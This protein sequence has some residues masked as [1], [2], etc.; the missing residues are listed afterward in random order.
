MLKRLFGVSRRHLPVLALVC[1]GVLV[2][3]FAFFSLRSLE[4]EKAK[5]A[6]L[7]A[8]QERMDDLQSDLDLTVNKVVS[9]GAFCESSYPVTR[10]SFDSFVT[11]VLSG[12]DAGIQ[13]LEWIPEVSLS[14]RAAFEKS[15]REGGSP[16][17]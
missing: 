12:R 13:A 17:I 8:A 16:G 6:F 10:T 14:Q 1:F 3:I 15:A 2:S 4:D 11:P 9:V 5:T 7:R